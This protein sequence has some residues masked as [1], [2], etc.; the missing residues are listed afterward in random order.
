M[1]HDPPTQYHQ[2]ASH[3]GSGLADGVVA[4]IGR[5][6]DNDVVLSDI[7]ASRHHARVVAAQG[8]LF[9]EDLR[10]MNGTQ[11]G[12]ANISRAPLGPEDV[13]TIGSTRLRM[14]G[15][16]LVPVAPGTGDLS[17]VARHVSF[18]LPSGKTLLDDVGFVVPPSSLVAVIG[19]SGA[20]K[21]TLL[22]ALTGSQPAISGSVHFD[23]RDMYRDH[24]EMRQR[25]GLV[26]QEDVVHRQLTVRQA[27]RYAAELRFPHDLERAA[28]LARVE[29]VLAELSLTEHSTTRI[30]RL[31]GGQRKR[32]SVA[33]ELLTRPSL[34]FL[35]EPTS[36]LDPL[37]EV[38][39]Q[40]CIAEATAR[41]RTVLLS[42][43]ILAEVEKLCDRVTII[44]AGRTVQAGTLAELRH[45]T[46]TRIEAS[47]VEDPAHLRDVPALH[48]VV[49]EGSRIT[50]DVDP[51]DLDEALR[52][53]V[54]HGVR[55]LVSAPPALEELFL[56]HYGDDLAE[57][58][59]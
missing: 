37:M 44:R 13:I 21:S 43:H 22:R 55:E 54:A 48:D 3:H 33:L 7:Q 41:G 28:R 40:R 51:E 34:L 39:F 23:A 38:V 42:S 26:P 31:S 12:G 17:L 2:A 8:R 57:A 4:T 32:V 9:V 35:D 25:V 52:A 46:R 16:T 18:T 1:T 14:E 30:D 11:L 27:L 36:G 59:R 5:A 56:R 45:L 50:F 24:A 19:P 6:L 49:V 20:G 29:E 53:L 58:G 47:L 10:S 15:R